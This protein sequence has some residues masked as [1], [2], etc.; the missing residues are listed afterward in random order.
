MVNV[1]HYR[2]RALYFSV[3]KHKQV[4]IPII[5]H[6]LQFLSILGC[7]NAMITT[8]LWVT[9]T[10]M[11]LQGVLKDEKYGGEDIGEMQKKKFK[12]LIGKKEN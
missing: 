11:K 7:V 4:S 3:Q 10:R 5:F 2:P 6:T 9:N 12:G 1:L 8:P